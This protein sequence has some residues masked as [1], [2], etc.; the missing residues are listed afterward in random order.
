[1]SGQ[2]RAY[3]EHLETQI[4]DWEIDDL[5]REATLTLPRTPVRVKSWRGP[6]V[7]LAV[8]MLVLAFGGT[9]WL[10][11]EEPS[12]V[13]APTP[14]TVAPTTATIDPTPET[15]DVGSLV[16]SRVPFD[17]VAFRPTQGAGMSDVVAWDGGFVAVGETNTP[18]DG[19]WGVDGA[20]WLSPDGVT[21]TLLPNGDRPLGGAQKQDIGAITTGGPGLV[22]VGQTLDDPDTRSVTSSWT[23]SAV[24]TSEDG[25]V[26]T[27]SPLAG[28]LNDVTAGGPGVVAVGRDSGAAA[29]W[30]SPDGTTWAR[31]PHDP[32]IF[33]HGGGEMW[34]V[35]AGEAGLVA[36][37]WLNGTGAVWTSPD[38]LDWSVHLGAGMEHRSVHPPGIQAV[39]ATPQGF[40]G[41]GNEETIEDACGEGAPG[42]CRV[43]IWT[44]PD[45]VTW[46]RVP[47]DDDVLGG[48][49]DKQ[50]AYAVTAVGDQIVVAGS[51]V[52][53][54]SDGRTWSRSYEDSAIAGDREGWMR[55]VAASNDAVVVVG[56]SPTGTSAVVW[57]GTPNHGA[58]NPVQWPEQ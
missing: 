53:T 58:G 4:N 41:I 25:L 51:S 35:A 26:W 3:A 20:V 18:K 7:G 42:D 46:T 37:G 48:G 52:W 5:F 10:L 44:S 2:V 33:G 6:L 21:W 45:G 1:M 28:S 29:V 55:A 40:V 38:G 36:V 24:W 9:L 23:A 49:L 30:T 15:I 11:R 17:E 47:H 27:K 39:A 32:A 31:V 12:N 14:S 22:A 16:W 57:V 43:M 8:M 54:S 50:F 13:V 56:G 34:Q 19:D